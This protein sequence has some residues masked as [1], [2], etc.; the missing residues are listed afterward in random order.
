[1]IATLSNIT[2]LKKKLKNRKI[3]PLFCNVVAWKKSELF[4]EKRINKGLN[5]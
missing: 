1:M 4:R 2:K 5:K 3:E